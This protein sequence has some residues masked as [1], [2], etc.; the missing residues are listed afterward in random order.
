MQKLL[1][2]LALCGV[3]IA[4]CANAALSDNLEHAGSSMLSRLKVGQRVK[5]ERAISGGYNVNIMNERLVKA[6]DGADPKYT[7]P[8]IINVGRD[9]I[10]V[11]VGSGYSRRD[12]QAISIRAIDVITHLD[13][14]DAVGAEKDPESKPQN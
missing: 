3:E 6:F 2:P 4:L 9:F 7:M 10:V 13:D 8:T 14:G 11:D 12:R 1:L 5:L